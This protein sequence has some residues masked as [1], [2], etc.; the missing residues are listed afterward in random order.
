MRFQTGATKNKIGRTPTCSEKEKQKKNE[1]RNCQECP[2]SSVWMARK[3]RKK[4]RE[5]TDRQEGIVRMGRHFILQMT[6]ETMSCSFYLFPFFLF[7]KPTLHVLR[8]FNGLAPFSSFTSPR[9]VR[10]FSPEILS[11]SLSI[12]CDKR[13]PTPERI[14]PCFAYGETNARI[15]DET[16]TH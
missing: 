7:L 13:F 6:L 2:E 1:Q 12:R 4:E 14:L 16:R 5:K 11:L 8:S 15:K 9:C 10:V 3:G